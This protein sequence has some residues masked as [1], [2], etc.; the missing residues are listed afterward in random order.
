MKEGL[1]TKIK[2][3][4]MVIEGSISDKHLE[5]VAREVKRIQTERRNGDRKAEAEKPGFGRQLK[6]FLYRAYLTVRYH[7]AH[8]SKLKAAAVPLITRGQSCAAS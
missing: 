4:N 8:K 5:D 1:T 7:K 3:G 2:N 6:R